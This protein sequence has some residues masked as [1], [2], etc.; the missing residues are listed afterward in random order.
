MPLSL[1]VAHA[2]CAREAAFHRLRTIDAAIR[3]CFSQPPSLG[4]SPESQPR[5]LIARPNDNRDA[6]VGKSRAKGC[7]FTG[8][9]MAL[10]DWMRHLMRWRPALPAFLLL[11]LVAEAGCHLDR[12]GLGSPTIDPNFRGCFTA[13]LEGS[14]PLI[15]IIQ[16]DRN[17]LEG[18]GSGIFPGAEGWSFTGHVTAIHAASLYVSPP[19]PQEAPF[20]VEAMLSDDS[21]SLSLDKPSLPRAH[22]VLHRCVGI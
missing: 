13:P 18:T 3:G 21:D 2:G 9:V 7:S 17:L 19:S 14:S 12:R 4:V 6:S 16:H 1:L 22:L 5:I 11:A 8:R 15:L 20:T 10:P